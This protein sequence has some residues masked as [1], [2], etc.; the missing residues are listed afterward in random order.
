MK[1]VL[2]R[3]T[4]DPD[5]VCAAAASSCY[6]ANGASD[7]HHDLSDKKV[8]RLLE[9]TVGRGHHSV[10]EHAVFTFSLE[11]VSRTLTHQ[12]VRHRIA[13]YSQQSQRYVRFD[14]ATY[15]TPPEVEDSPE[16]KRVFDRTI[17][18]AWQAY[19]ELVEAGIPE[20][21]ARFVL[22]N[23][24][25]TNITITMNARE[26]LHF[27]RLR[28]CLRAQ[29]EIRRAA[30][31]MLEECRRVAPVIFENAGRPCISGPC[32]DDASDCPLFP[33]PYG[34]L[35]ETRKDTPK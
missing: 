14:E 35:D 27:F 31:K 26:L 25:T 28:C 34:P 20:E 33:G 16:A 13:S 6:S 21:D 22:P 4:Q 9:H 3:H 11:G 15:V 19:R 5:R 12:L 7:L 10:V 24:A 29:W 23:A 30:L 32:P 18:E 2:L 8:R 17:E 1:V